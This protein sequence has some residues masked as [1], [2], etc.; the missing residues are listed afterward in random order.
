[1]IRSCYDKDSWKGDWSFNSN[2]WNSENKISVISDDFYK[3]RYH[4]YLEKESDLEGFIDPKTGNFDIKNFRFEEYFKGD[5]WMSFRDL[6]YYFEQ[7]VYCDVQPGV[8][9]YNQKITVDEKKN[10]MRKAFKLRMTQFHQC[11]FSIQKVY[12]KW[13]KGS[14]RENEILKIMVGKLKKLFLLLWIFKHRK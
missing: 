9:F 4:G 7:I 12:S 13:K 14:K 11:R 10:V 2:K 6:L 1:M 5:F 8:S 3:E